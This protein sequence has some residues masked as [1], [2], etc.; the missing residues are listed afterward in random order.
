MHVPS[1]HLNMF[2]PQ[3][4]P[5]PLL[6]LLPPPPPPDEDA[7]DA[8]L[9]L[10]VVVELPVPELLDAVVVIITSPWAQPQAAANSEPAS[11]ESRRSRVTASP[12]GQP[13]KSVHGSSSAKARAQ[14][15]PW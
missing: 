10:L 1:S 9:V 12:P 15:A 11:K 3:P 8:L 4:P 13:S 5:A 7:D 14:G 6:L 2:A